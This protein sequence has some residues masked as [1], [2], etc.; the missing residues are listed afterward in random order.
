[1][2]E[3]LSILQNQQNTKQTQWLKQ[4]QW[5][6][7]ER[8]YMINTKKIKEGNAYLKQINTSEGSTWLH[9]WMFNQSQWMTWM[10]K[11][12][13]V[14]YLSHTPSLHVP[15]IN[16]CVQIIWHP[17]NQ[18]QAQKIS[19]Y[20]WPIK[21]IWCKLKK[22]MWTWKH[23]GWSK[24]RIYQTLKDSSNLKLN[25]GESNQAPYLKTHFS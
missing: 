1:M 21:I 2:H 5:S 25:T 19:S 24:Q 14:E 12:R 15:P 17:I 7:S 4:S 3:H 18:P 16:Q 6:R 22:W 8:W 23:H 10:I 11:H 13:I 20:S 9:Q